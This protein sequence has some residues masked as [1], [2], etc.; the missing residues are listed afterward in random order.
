MDLMA[1]MSSGK[2][3]ERIGAILFILADSYGTVHDGKVQ[4]KIPLTRQE[5][6]EMAGTTTESTIRV[7]SR[8]QKEGLISTDRHVITLEDVPALETIVAG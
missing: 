8:W 4:L 3:E 1:K 2:V 6:S 7:M 5:I